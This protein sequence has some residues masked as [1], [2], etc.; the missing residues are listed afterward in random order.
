MNYSQELFESVSKWDGSFASNSEVYERIKRLVRTIM[1]QK[2]NN[3]NEQDFE[4]IVHDTTQ[5][6]MEKVF[7]EKEIQNWD[8]YIS[9]T[10]YFKM[11]AYFGS[12][13]TQEIVLSPDIDS[14]IGITFSREHYTGKM[15]GP[16][17][18]CEVSN[19][20]DNCLHEISKLLEKVPYIGE[21][22]TRAINNIIK[23]ASGTS[24]VSSST[25]EERVIKIYAILIFKL[26][27]KKVGNVDLSDIADVMESNESDQRYKQ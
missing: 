17:D 21:K 5:E 7:L 12:K 24:Y 10:I 8:S 27:N 16:E 20:V 15:T 13:Y 2:Y 11:S 19:N 6:M 9:S 23:A 4:E 3:I 18:L 14:L 22:K 25:Q 1:A 26:L